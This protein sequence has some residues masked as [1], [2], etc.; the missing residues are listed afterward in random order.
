MF[1]P[2][3]KA[4]SPGCA[5]GV[6][7]QGKLVYSKGFGA[8]NL[9]LGVPIT[10]RTVFDIGSVS[11]QFTA[12][13]VVLLAED[14]K[15]SLD[16]EIHRFVP[17][18]PAYGAPVTL[19]SMLHHSSGLPSYTDLFDLAG[20][21]ESDLTTDDDAL[22]LIARQRMLNFAPGRQY[23]Y[24][25]TNYF[26]LSLVVRRV[27][28]ETLREFARRRIF[29]PLGMRST[30]FHDDHRMIVPRRATG[31]A[32][33]PGG[34]FDIDMSNFE[35][36]GDGSIMTTVEDLARWD[37][38]FETP[39]VGDKR[40]V[41]LLQEPGVRTDGS[42]TPYAMGLIL[43]EYRGVARVQHTGEWV[44]YRSSLLQFPKAK[45]SVILLCNAIGDLDP[46]ALSE[47]V[48]DIYLRFGGSPSGQAPPRSA[49]PASAE[50][51]SYT[52]AYWNAETF[53]YL[54]FVEQA[55]ALSLEGE[56]AQRL[57]YLGPGEFA[58]RNSS[59]RYS[60]QRA[61]DRLTVRART[62][63]SDPVIL[64]HMP[65]NPVRQNDLS[66]YAG[67]YYSEALGVS[68]TLAIRNARL[69]RSQWMFPAQEL[70]AVLPDTFTGDL[71]EGGYALQFTR[72][73]AGK[74][75]GFAVGTS[76]VRPLHFSRCEPAAPQGGG[77]LAL[78]CKADIAPFRGDGH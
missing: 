56:S 16:D 55:G 20:I 60:F 51:A 47:R 32:P 58:G 37:R 50:I 42:Q 4:F 22:A 57:V 72:N 11:K 17:E 49:S 75:D 61:A 31:Y 78:G 24:S 8:A 19:R 69:T 35:Q 63:D 46:L 52:G 65:E 48:A 64:E 66:E 36:L 6:V 33:R 30:H 26:L 67:V 25:D 7:Q 59:I 29:V 5:L 76:M 41:A 14:G 74:V 45:L 1:E 62:D 53:A 39:V 10:P 23:L 73:N 44:G 15:L 38:N 40:A 34:G 68:W 77:P 18:L 3:N 2:W 27:S 28:G 9:E 12:M 70:Q 54:R 21:P 71:T 43:D 13:S